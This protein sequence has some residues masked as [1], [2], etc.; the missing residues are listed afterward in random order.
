MAGPSGRQ[1]SVS[2][3]RRGSR[4]RRELPAGAA[5]ESDAQHAASPS[6][7]TRD[8][9]AEMTAVVAW[10]RR[11]CVWE[12]LLHQ[13]QVGS[14]LASIAGAHKRTK[15]EHGCTFMKHCMRRKDWGY[16]SP[17]LCGLRVRV[18]RHCLSTSV[19]YKVGPMAAQRCGYWPARACAFPATSRG[20]K[21][22][23]PHASASAL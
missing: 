11:R 4:F 15:H 20:G 3:G 16:S 5:D 19:S 17:Y 14:A 18:Y 13:L 22:R 1:G 9:A 6:Q 12:K 21:A 23:A 7:G 10:C 8:M 2:S